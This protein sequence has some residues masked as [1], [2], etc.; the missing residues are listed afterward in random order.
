MRHA[1]NGYKTL[2]TIRVPGANIHV[3]LS[4]LGTRCCVYTGSNKEDTEYRQIDAGEGEELHVGENV[5]VL[6]TDKISVL[7]Q[8]VQPRVFVKGE[9][10]KSQ[11]IDTFPLVVL[12]EKTNAHDVLLALQARYANEVHD[13]YTHST[14]SS[15]KLDSLLDYLDS[16]DGAI[17]RSYEHMTDISSKMSRLMEDTI[18]RSCHG[19]S[20][21]EVNRDALA[22]LNV[23]L[24]DAMVEYRQ[25]CAEVVDRSCSILLPRQAEFSVP[26]K[27]KAPRPAPVKESLVE[28]PP[29]R[30]VREAPAPRKR[31]AP[32][33]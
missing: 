4:P 23:E 33:T 22:S 18:L 32:R 15:R 27:G 5:V 1:E 7:V 21:I 14:E 20:N 10:E 25:L 24:Q 11:V 16:V 12:D 30:I 13:T 3:C 29:P 31:G 26:D 2:E 8:G 19:D 17:R 6:Y 9:V 28:R